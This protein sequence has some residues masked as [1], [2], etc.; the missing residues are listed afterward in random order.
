M[1]DVRALQAYHQPHGDG[2]AAAQWLSHRRA[3]RARPASRA[4]R[5]RAAT[6]VARARARAPAH[7]SPRGC[8]A[9]RARARRARATPS[10]SAVAMSTPRPLQYGESGDPCKMTYSIMA[11]FSRPCSSCKARA[12]VVVHARAPAVRTQSERQQQPAH[13]RERLHAAHTFRVVSIAP[14]IDDELEEDGSRR[15]EAAA[16]ATAARGPA[17]GLEHHHTAARRAASVLAKK[18]QW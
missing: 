17:R 12:K 10:T 18:V 9:Q 4:G 13:A 14:C 2:T 6:V 8:R 3:R 16:R 15:K 7:P 11:F 5:A 1:Q